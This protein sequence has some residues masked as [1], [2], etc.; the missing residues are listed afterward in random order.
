MKNLLYIL[1]AVVVAVSANSVS[2]IWAKQESKLS[3]WLLVVILISPMV[4]ITYGVVTSLVG[5]AI[6][7]KQRDLTP[8]LDPFTVFI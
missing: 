2:A 4:F 8:L 6:A 7:S 5:L 3:L 1:V